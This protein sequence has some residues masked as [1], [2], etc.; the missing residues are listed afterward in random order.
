M[1]ACKANA[2]EIALYL[3]E[4]GVDPNVQDHAGGDTYKYCP[5][6]DF[7]DKIEASDVAFVSKAVV[8]NMLR[9][10]CAAGGEKPL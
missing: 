1:L 2:L 4:Q 7:R 3:I 6:K 10:I 5:T 8:G 9:L